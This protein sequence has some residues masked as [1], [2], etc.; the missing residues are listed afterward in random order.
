MTSTQDIPPSD[1]RVGIE[2]SG[3]HVALVV[4]DTRNGH[5]DHDKVYVLDWKQSVIK[6]IIK[7]KSRRYTS[8]IFVSPDVLL[9]TNSYEGSLELWRIPSN[10]V[11]ESTAPDLTLLLPT[12]NTGFSVADLACRGAPNPSVSTPRNERPFRSSAEDSI[13]VFHLYVSF[14]NPTVITQFLFFTHR[15]AL[16]DL[17]AEPG[18][19]ARSS[20]SPE[21]PEDATASPDKSPI[22]S[23]EGICW[24]RWGHPITRWFHGRSITT[25]WITT[26]CGQRFVLIN[27]QAHA[28]AQP[29]I[30]LDFNQHHCKQLR[31]RET[32]GDPIEHQVWLVKEPDSLGRLKVFKE[33][34]MGLL[35]YVATKSAEVYGYHGVLMDDE[36]I[37]GLKKAKSSS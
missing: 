25:D 24:T 16:L 13:I 14:I 1:V 33:E 7:S 31:Y 20:P 12:L 15:R 21:L 28:M 23:N 17:L 30:I 19:L 10:P 35:P 32:L 22:P 26:T 37:I 2:I 8:A 3:D 11:S 6:M 18:S 36:R 27:P 29:V 9:V 4:K 5:F 34:V